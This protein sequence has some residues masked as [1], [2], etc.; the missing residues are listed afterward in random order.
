MVVD[1]EMITVTGAGTYST[2][3]TNVATLVGTYTWL[4]SYAGDGLNNGA[5][6][7]GGADEQGQ[8]E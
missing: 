3:N 5:I 7:Q 6:D 4:A 1:T 2:T 8:R